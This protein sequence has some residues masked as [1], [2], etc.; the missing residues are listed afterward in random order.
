M[1]HFGFLVLVS[2][3]QL[4][5][6]VALVLLHSMHESETSSIEQFPAVEYHVIQVVAFQRTN[7]QI[8]VT[9]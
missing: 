8:A 7:T 3:I 5:H 6:S 2:L 9:Q 1:E 4:Y